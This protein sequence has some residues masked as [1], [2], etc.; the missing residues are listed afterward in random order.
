MNEIKNRYI[1]LS[2]TIIRN[3][4]VSN[5]FHIEIN[6]S[7]IKVL[8]FCFRL[9]N[10]MFRKTNLFNQCVLSAMTHVI[11]EPINVGLNMLLSGDRVWA[12]EIYLPQ[13]R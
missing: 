5:S 12:N 6:T 9:I 2:A 8:F 4:G 7:S 13:I 1:V 3:S 11:T 10:T